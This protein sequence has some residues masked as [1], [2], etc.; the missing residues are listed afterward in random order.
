MGDTGKKDKG[1]REKQKKATLTQ[2]EKR[3][4]KREKKR[5]Q[6]STALRDPSAVQRFSQPDRSV[7][8]VPL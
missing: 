5:A 3:Q 4:Q 2:K 6:S 7:R 1:K 8:G